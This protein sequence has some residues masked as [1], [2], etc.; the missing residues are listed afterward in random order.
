MGWI[1]HWFQVVR[2]EVRIMRSR[3]IYLLGS[4][5]VMAVSAL[6]FITFFGEGLPQKLRIGVVEFSTVSEACR[7]LETGRINGFVVIPHYFDRE[8]QSFHSPKMEVYV[9]TMYPVIG[10]SLA[11]KDIL[12][13]VNL[14]NGAV[15]RQL[16]RAK[17]MD[18]KEIMDRIQPLSVDAHA[19]GNGPTNY[20]YYLVNMILMGMLAMSVT[21]ITA[22]SVGSELKYGTSKHLLET[23]DGSIVVGIL[24]KM[25][26]YTLLFS[27]IGIVLQ[28]LL[29]GPL[30]YPM[31]GSMGWL[32][33]STLVFILACQAV[34]V[35]IVSMVPTLR[36][37]VCISALYSVLGFSFA[38][39][40]LPI[41]SLPA[42]LQGM[43]VIF[44]LRFY[45]QLYVREVLY[46]TGFAGWWI[47]LV[48]MLLFLFLPLAG[49]IRLK[50][51][52]Q[53]Q[54]YPRN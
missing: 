28:L 47:Y 23:A 6:F 30:H 50:N 36:L 12:Y 20:A 37:G 14:T 3:P 19:I 33:L 44:P 15:Q 5:G 8:L 13:M 52:Y 26:P 7:E 35:F 40:T 51:A 34:G 38:G 25:A 17:G 31:N 24:G 32:I 4:V 53:Y 54:N 45:Y 1:H 29:Y 11:Y 41:S 49:A 46:G 27:V 21:L 16:L 43:S 2:R 10:G 39:F 22:Y 48:L 9:N 18:E 42:A